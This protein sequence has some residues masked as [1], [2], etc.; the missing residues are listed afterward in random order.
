MSKYLLGFLLLLFLLPNSLFAQELVQGIKNIWPAEVV[1]VISEREENIPGTDTKTTVQ[2]ISVRLTDGEREGEIVTF[3]NDMVRLS[4]GDKIYV[5]YVKDMGGQEFFYLKDV[6]RQTPMIVLIVLFVSLLAVFAGWQGLRALLSLVGS[7]A[8]ILFVLVPAMLAGYDP[9]LVSLLVA[10]VILTLAIL[11]THGLN[12]ISITALAGTFGAVLVTSVVAWTFVYWMRLTGFGDDASVPLNFATNGELDF[13][14]LLLGS[15]IIGVLG[16][17]DDVSITQ[18]S[19]VTELKKANPALRMWQLY[20]RA[21][22]VGRDHV[23]SLVN[24]LALAY[25]G[26]ALPLVLLFSTSQ[27]PLSLTLNQELIAAEIVRIIVGSIGLILAV[28]LSTIL[29]AWWFDSR[30]VGDDLAEH[31]HHH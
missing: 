21:I 8:A 9:V 18:A 3:D 17:L 28:P 29:A 20:N 19:V 22:K 14:G 16:V 30:T 4:S 13:V 7:V 26:A 31:T 6:R 5:T 10:G 25:V 2:N 11:G 12:P 24:T 1:S 27:Y 23:G 15:I